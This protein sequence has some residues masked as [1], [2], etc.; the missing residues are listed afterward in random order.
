[1]YPGIA[2]EAARRAVDIVTQSC[3]GDTLR[4]TVKGKRLTSSDVQPA[5]S[6]CDTFLDFYRQD[7]SGPV[8]FG[9]ADVQY[10]MTKPMW[11]DLVYPLQ[12]VCDHDVD[13]II[14]VRCFILAPDNSP[15]LVGVGRFTVR[16]LIEAGKNLR[17]NMEHPSG[18][19]CAGRLKFSSVSVQR[20]MGSSTHQ[21]EFSTIV[22]AS[23]GDYYQLDCPSY[24]PPV[25]LPGGS[26]APIW[27]DPRPPPQD[28][29]D[30]PPPPIVAALPPPPT[31]EYTPP[32]IPQT[33]PVPQ[34]DSAAADYLNLIANP[35]DPPVP[36]VY[37]FEDQHGVPPAQF[38]STFS[39]T[40]R[41][42]TPKKPAP[43]APDPS[44]V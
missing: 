21:V 15:A 3:P 11:K 8:K 1:M 4:F 6:K 19:P 24:E 41:S 16:Q 25:I 29:F 32:S 36:T 40:G 42:T 18:N 30:R 38:Y 7:A 44:G 35:P 22:P 13:R 28:R 27:V 5:M 34:G 12:D 9:T 43:S 23:S 37:T 17:V 2:Y 39:T 10:G 20:V 26:S 14:I 31:T 33:P